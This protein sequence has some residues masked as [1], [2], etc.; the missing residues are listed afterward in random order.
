MSV[1]IFLPPLATILKEEEEE[2]LAREG[3]PLT[4]EDFSTV[5]GAGLRLKDAITED[6]IST[7]HSWW[8]ATTTTTLLLI[9]YYGQQNMFLSLIII[10]I[11]TIGFVMFF[12][13]TWHAMCGRV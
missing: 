2:V 5:K 7:Q 3:R 13:A 8:V 4:E 9:V 6:A 1:L 10:L 12:C 11:V